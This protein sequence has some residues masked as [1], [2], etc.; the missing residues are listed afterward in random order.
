[1][2]ISVLF[3][4][5]VISNQKGGGNAE[6]TFQLA[7][8]LN[9]A[10]CK[11]SILSLDIGIENERPSKLSGLDLVILNCIN[12]R[13][14]IPF[15][16]LIKIFN[17]VMAIDIV[18]IIGHWSPLG[19]IACGISKFLGKPYT[20]SPAGALLPYGRSRYLKLLFNSVVGKCI[21]KNASGWISITKKEISDF[22]LF[23]IPCN[24]VKVIPNGVDID[25]LKIYCS[26]DF[27]NK[28]DIPKNPYILFMGRLNIIKGPDILLEAFRIISNIYPNYHLVFSGPD[29][30]M[31]LLLSKLSR[32]YGLD[33]RVHFTGFISGCNKELAY[34]DAILLVVPSRS[35]AMSLVAVE[36]GLHATPVL[37]TDECGL[38]D[39]GEIDKKLIVPAQSKDLAY[40]LEYLL[41]NPDRLEIYG[42]QWR[43]MVI[44]R[45][46]WKN[47]SNDF[48][49]FLSEIVAKEKN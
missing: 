18:H 3:V 42:I 46:L 12:E 20:I 35:E 23:S 15:P 29:E 22:T 28:F 10:G 44:A 38:E 21:V 11:V 2:A 45:F 8:A 47:I 34:R 39:I 24:K 27:C 6:R 41:A 5:S 9:H 13:Y 19:V 14:Q 4:V 48:I 25:A 43:E 32:D 17:A 37:L 30:G 1:M 31:K 40:S 16:S 36:A 7:R 49:N 33:E 26:E